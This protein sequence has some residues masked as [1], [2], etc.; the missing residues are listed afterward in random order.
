[1]QFENLQGAA[2]GV[3]VARAEMRLERLERRPDELIE[4]GLPSLG[5]SWQLRATTQP[6][7]STAGFTQFGG[8]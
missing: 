7:A 1:L 2:P 6:T 3:A 8:G 5:S 4:D